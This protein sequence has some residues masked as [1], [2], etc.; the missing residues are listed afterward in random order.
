MT[1]R[2]MVNDINAAEAEA[3]LQPVRE[4]LNNAFSSRAAYA[5][6][7]ATMSFG[8]VN[9]STGMISSFCQPPLGLTVD[10]ISQFYTLPQE[11]K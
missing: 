6:A 9:V 1:M 2:R 7:A 10:I 11:E 4:Q 5:R 3:L 8:N